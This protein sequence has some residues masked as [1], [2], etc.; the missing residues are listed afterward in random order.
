MQ[1]VY[2]V[3]GIDFDSC[4]ALADAIR[5][6]TQNQKPFREF[7]GCSFIA[8]E[9]KLYVEVQ[10]NADPTRLAKLMPYVDT[11]VYDLARELRERTP[12]TVNVEPVPRGLPDYNRPPLAR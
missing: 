11:L 3:P 8:S 2:V 9:G 10:D 12:Q 6:F 5:S 4:N 7:V 1:F